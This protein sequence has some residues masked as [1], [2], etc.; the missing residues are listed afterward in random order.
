MKFTVPEDAEENRKSLDEIVHKSSD[1][2][3]LPEKVSNLT[4]KDI[5]KRPLRYVNTIKLSFIKKH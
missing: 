2:I 4:E 3:E 1:G 5:L